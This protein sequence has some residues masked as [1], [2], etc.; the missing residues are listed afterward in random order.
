KREGVKNVEMAI[1]KEGVLMLAYA[2]VSPKGVKNR[3]NTAK[4]IDF[5]LR[6]EPQVKAATLGGGLPTN[7]TAKWP[8]DFQETFG[9]TQEDLMKVVYAPDWSKI[10]EEDEER[11]NMVEELMADAPRWRAGAP[12]PRRPVSR[13]RVIMSNEKKTGSIDVAGV[14]KS[15]G[16]TEVLRE[17]S[18]RI[19]PGSCVTLLGPSGCGKTTPQ[20]GRASCRGSAAGPGA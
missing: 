6:A 11:V 8:A 19:E 9:I 5:Q 4:F 2:T 20:I 12:R 17:V 16:D 1:P 3:A 18:L 15:Y 10:V 13:L 7:K 14:S